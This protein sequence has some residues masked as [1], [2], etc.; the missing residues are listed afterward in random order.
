MGDIEAVFGIDLACKKCD[1][2]R[3]EMLLEKIA[4]G[5]PEGMDT[6]R[7]A[8]YEGG[9]FYP[10]YQR[11]ILQCTEC[12]HLIPIIFKPK[13]GKWKGIEQILKEGE[14]SVRRAK[15]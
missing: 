12:G 9:H 3:F 14:K 1:G 6:T 11:A 7:I 10:R 4:E 8:S 15:G 2:T 5:N 13:Q